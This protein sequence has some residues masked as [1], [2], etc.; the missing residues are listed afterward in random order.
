MGGTNIQD[1]NGYFEQIQDSKVST[2]NPKG[3]L[4]S[5]K[6]IQLN[7]FDVEIQY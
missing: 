2:F 7:M 1:F 6:S 4:R 3:H 5:R